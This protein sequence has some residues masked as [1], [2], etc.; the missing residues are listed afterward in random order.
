MKYR[1]WHLYTRVYT[2]RRFITIDHKHN[3]SKK[4]K[5]LSFECENKVQHDLKY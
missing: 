5:T 3:M 1:Y 2:Q 4:E